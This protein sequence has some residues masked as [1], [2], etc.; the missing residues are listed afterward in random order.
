MNVANRKPTIHGKNPLQVAR[1]F[2]NHDVLRAMLRKSV[3]AK[4]EKH[5][6]KWWNRKTASAFYTWMAKSKAASLLI[7][8]KAVRRRSVD[9]TNAIFDA[10]SSVADGSAKTAPAHIPPGDSAQLVD[11]GASL[12]T[13]P[14]SSDTTKALAD[15]PI[16]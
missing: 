8:R 4:A 7:R 2:G 5:F 16:A 15:A 1:E 6:S 12:T 10:Q 9:Q 11:S 14:E 13:R 3:L